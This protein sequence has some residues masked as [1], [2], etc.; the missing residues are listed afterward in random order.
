MNLNYEK[1]WKIIEEIIEQEKRH[2]F[3]NYISW[4]T[5]QSMIESIFELKPIINT[6]EFWLLFR[7]NVRVLKLKNWVAQKQILDSMIMIYDFQR[8]YY[9]PDLESFYGIIE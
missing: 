3:R 8:N 1:E 5:K 7:E 4:Q 6:E 2:N 9:L